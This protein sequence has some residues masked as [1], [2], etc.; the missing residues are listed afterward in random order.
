MREILFRGKTQKGEWVYGSG[1]HKEAY[2]DEQSATIMGASR[3][4]SYATRMECSYK[5]TYDVVLPE[6]VGEY[7]GLKDVEDNKIFEGDI[8]TGKIKIAPINLLTHSGS[9]K[10][11]IEWA[12][13]SYQL[14]R[15]DGICDPICEINRLK[16]IGNIFDNPEL[17]RGDK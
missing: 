8:V 17:L 5:Y 3:Y 11:V 16:I 9:V 10:G 15:L 1:A 7:T 6:T 12:L 2:D 4:P 14:V 13:S